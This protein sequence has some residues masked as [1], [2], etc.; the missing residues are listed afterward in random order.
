MESDHVFTENFQHGKYLIFHITPEGLS[1][2]KFD[3][4]IEEVSFSL[5]VHQGD[6]MCLYALKEN[7]NPCEVI[8]CEQPGFISA[9]L[10]TVPYGTYDIGNTKIPDEFWQAITMLDQ[11][12]EIDLPVEILDLSEEI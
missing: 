7:Q 8:E 10:N 9:K 11:K 1:V 5:D 6:V 4:G 12:E 3:S 2:Y